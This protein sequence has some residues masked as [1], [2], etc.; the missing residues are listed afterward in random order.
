MKM[1]IAPAAEYSFTELAGTTRNVLQEIQAL[2]E[3]T[4]LGRYSEE[5]IKNHKEAL[6]KAL[7]TTEYLNT[8]LVWC[9]QKPAWAAL[10][11]AQAGAVSKFTVAVR[12]SGLTPVEAC[13]IR[14]GEEFMLEYTEEENALM[15]SLRYEVCMSWMRMACHLKKANAAVV[16]RVFSSIVIGSGFCSCD[17][18][19]VNEFVRGTTRQGGGFKHGITTS[20][21]IVNMHPVS[22]ITVPNLYSTSCALENTFRPR[23]KDRNR[24]ALAPCII[25]A[26][27][28]AEQGP[29]CFGYFSERDVLS[30]TPRHM[31]YGKALTAL[32]ADNEKVKEL[33]DKANTNGTENLLVYPND[34]RWVQPYMAGPHSCMADSTHRYYTDYVDELDTAHPVDAYCAAMMGSGDNGLVLFTLLDSAEQPKARAIVSVRDYAG[35][36]DGKIQGCSF[37]R[38]YGDHALYRVLVSLGITQEDHALEDHFLAYIPQSHQRFVGPYIDGY[39][40]YGTIHADERRVYISEDGEIEM[41][42]TRGVYD[43]REVKYCACCEERYAVDDMREAPNGQWVCDDCW[44]D[45]VGTCAISGREYMQE[46]LVEI[47]LDGYQELVHE[48]NLDEVVYDEV[49]EEYYTTSSDPDMVTIE[50]G[51][52]T[53]RDN[54]VRCYSEPMEDDSDTNESDIIRILR[55]EYDSSCYGEI[56]GEYC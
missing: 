48:D 54:T 47:V 51:R 7:P 20:L 53:V 37:V 31:P 35:I 50:D 12:E 42:E 29:M 33:V 30:G 14:C 1:T 24:H 2:A 34:T 11:A 10:K 16:F 40:V 32:G 25:M 6:K 5:H 49:K 22:R 9:E 8:M 39:C 55:C 18:D 19:T 46:D 36:K 13:I 45:A 23:Q 26:Y 3:Q 15:R 17:E 21:G 28:H 56:I 52:S 38:N 4:V 27:Y 41:Q 43:E 44:D